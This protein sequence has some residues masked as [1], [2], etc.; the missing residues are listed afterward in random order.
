[1][2]SVVFS[3]NDN[4]A[5]LLG[6]ALCSLFENRRGDYPVSIFIMDGGISEK[7]RQR[8]AELKTRYQ[9]ELTYLLPDRALFESM[10]LPHS[11]PAYYR[12]SIGALLPAICHRAIYLDC[13][14]IIRGD[15]KELFDVG[16]AGNTVGAVHDCPQDWW[17]EHV[18]QL[19]EDIPEFGKPQKLKYFNSGMLLIDLDRWRKRNIGEKLFQ[20]IR[21]HP[22]KLWVADQ[23][24]L[25]MVLL[26]DWKQLSA[27]YNFIPVP[28]NSTREDDPLVVHFAGGIKPWYFFSAL[29]FQPEYVHYA[30]LT[31]WKNM[32][33]RKFMDVPFT[34]KYHFYPLAW[35]ARGVYKRLKM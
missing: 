19:S 25:N 33:Y 28:H 15:I 22:D 11:L 2:I 7:N 26:N 23:D 5:M 31:S 29:P 4:H 24:P 1:M 8:L 14:V 35:W 16:L 17:K 20:F 13:D 27:R 18:K 32:K 6:V 12:V 10:N 3:S 9:F 21:Q 34:K 30:N